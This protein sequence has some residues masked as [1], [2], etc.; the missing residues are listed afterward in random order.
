MQGLDAGT[1]AELEPLARKASWHEIANWVEQKHPGGTGLTPA[2]ALIYAVALKEVP[3][4]G[5]RAPLAAQADRLGI[6]AV[7]SLLGVGED[8][9]I[10]L[11][12]AK[13]ALRKRQLEWQKA[14]PKRVSITLMLV[15]LVIGA[16]V[17]LVLS[18]QSLPFHW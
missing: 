17:G 8:S 12:I 3:A 1:A 14:P 15:A 4:E 7:S 13:R 5:A 6:R 2:L 18:Q 9:A 16:A 10:A 11:V